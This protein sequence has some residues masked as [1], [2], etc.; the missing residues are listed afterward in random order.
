MDHPDILTAMQIGYPSIDYIEHEQ[1]Y[2]KTHYPVIDGH[3]IEDIFGSEIHSSDKY[4]MDA[5]GQAVLLENTRD[6]LTEIVGVV[7]YEAK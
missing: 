6:Y 4:F 5:N 2:S 7:F 3:P 1:N